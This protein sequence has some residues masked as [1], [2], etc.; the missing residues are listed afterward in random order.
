[1]ECGLVECGLVECGR[2]VECGL[3]AARWL[4]LLLGRLLREWI[5]L[6]GRSPA[7]APE[8]ALSFLS[9]SFFRLS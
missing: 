1:V 4:T 7:L 6:M 8:L 3:G 2:L 5:L 9:R